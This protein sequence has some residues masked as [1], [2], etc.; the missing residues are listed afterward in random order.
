MMRDSS[1]PGRP[2]PKTA[3]DACNGGCCYD[4]YSCA[5][6]T[7]AQ[8]WGC[9]L[10]NVPLCN[11]VCCPQYDAYCDGTAHCNRECEYGRT[12]LM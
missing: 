4:G 3:G 2:G 6:D 7:A 11:G 8:E 10:E 5:Y 12:Q 1:L 9:C